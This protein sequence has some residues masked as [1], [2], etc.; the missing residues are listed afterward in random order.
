MTGTQNSGWKAWLTFHGHTQKS[1]TEMAGKRPRELQTVMRGKM[2]K[3]TGRGSIP[4]MQP[5]QDR[6]RAS[7]YFTEPQPKISHRD[8]EL[9]E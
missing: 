4:R 6:R 9:P 3:P 2:G 5:P 8:L 1:P 7:D